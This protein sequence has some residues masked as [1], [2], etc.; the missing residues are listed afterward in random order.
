MPRYAVF[1]NIP[2]EMFDNTLK[3]AELVNHTMNDLIQKLPEPY[4]DK[5]ITV[6]QPVANFTGFDEVCWGSD[7]YALRLTLVA[8]D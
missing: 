8:Y 5:F 4:R 7:A 1:V 6:A 2:F 3:P